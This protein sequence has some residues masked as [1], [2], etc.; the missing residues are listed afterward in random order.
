MAHLVELADASPV[1]MWIA[2]P[3]RNCL[4]ANR[5]LLEYTG[6][7][8]DEIRM[9]GW[10]GDLHPDDVATYMALSR[11]AFAARKVYRGQYRY[12]R[13]DGEYQWVAQR[14]VPQFTAKGKFL[15]FIGYLILLEGP[16][17][18]PR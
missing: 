15:G 8:F 17:E 2:D 6:R 12:R 10:V 11:K 5:T 3:N 7:T 14:A 18:L 16:P 1:M 4:Y 9:R 13:A